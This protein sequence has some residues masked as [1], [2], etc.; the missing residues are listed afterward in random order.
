MF[1]ELFKPEDDDDD[2][3]DSG[4][5]Y[6]II[7]EGPCSHLR[8]AERPGNGGLPDTFQTDHLLYYER[9]KAYQ[10]YMLGNSSYNTSDIVDNKE[11]YKEPTD[12]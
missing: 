6:Y 3:D 2:D 7:D 8:R 12:V 5:H 1:S 10:D 4:T 9:F 11:M